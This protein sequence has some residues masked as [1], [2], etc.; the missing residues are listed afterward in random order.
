MK[1]VEIEKKM[2]FLV[3]FSPYWWMHYLIMTTDDCHI[4]S[5]LQKDSSQPG[6]KLFYNN[7]T[8]MLEQVRLAKTQHI[9]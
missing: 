3:C 6:I 8:E 9:G 5:D 1:L 2:K 4:A 7:I